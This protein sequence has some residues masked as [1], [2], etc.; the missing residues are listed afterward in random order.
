MYVISFD[1][2]IK[3]MAY[4]VFRVEKQQLEI[5]AWENL[6]MRQT[7]AAA[8]A[9]ASDGGGDPKPRC[10]GLLARNAPCGAR[11]EFC[12]PG[13]AEFWCA[14]HAKASREFLLP[15]PGLR[16]RAAAALA[17]KSAA[18]LRA[19][20]QYVGLAA[21][22]LPRRAKADCAR[23]VAEA[24][25]ARCFERVPPQQT[26]QVGSKRA[27]AD[28]AAMGRNM[29]R[30]FESIPFL[31]RVTHVLI[32]QQMTARMKTLQGMVAQYFIMR[33]DD[34]ARV[35]FV[36]PRHKLKAFR[37]QAQDHQQQ[38]RSGGGGGGGGYQENKADA[39]RYCLELF[40][41]AAARGLAL[42][43]D[44]P[45]LPPLLAAMRAAQ[46]KAKFDDYADCFLQ[47]YWWIN[48]Q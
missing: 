20:E 31:D 9:A 8:A 18:E 34:G 37:A 12:K 39:V 44:N 24:L 25:D 13:R 3:N 28:F 42:H 32:E 38:Q 26:P 36:S 6:D 4:C 11:V 19:L 29:K 17:R 45:A 46:K 23:E 40:D 5:L 35:L 1:I 48:N 21:P 43:A 47:G 30:R 15:P 16:L 14:R 22:P 41:A 7:A 2:G 10:C 33:L 27:N